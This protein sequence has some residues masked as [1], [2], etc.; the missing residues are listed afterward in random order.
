M[1]VQSVEQL[2]AKHRPTRDRAE[3]RSVRRV[4]VRSTEAAELVEGVAGVV[5]DVPRRLLLR[6]AD[7]VDAL[8]LPHDPAVGV[9]D[10]VPAELC[11]RLIEAALLGVEVILVRLR[12]VGE[13]A[14]SQ[15]VVLIL[16]IGTAVQIRRRVRDVLI[17]LPDGVALRD[18]LTRAAVAA[19]SHRAPVDAWEHV[20]L[21]V[22]RCRLRDAGCLARQIGIRRALAEA[23]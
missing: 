2:R 5:R 18:A 21:E 17:G 8:T 11:A 1:T 23:E 12:A 20:V 4:D 9:A 6:V 10:E 7:A 13:L 15:V 22:S 16:R 14:H 19:R 3:R